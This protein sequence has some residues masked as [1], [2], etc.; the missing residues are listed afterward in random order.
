MM[1][2]MWVRD[3]GIARDELAEGRDDGEGIEVVGLPGG[4]GDGGRGTTRVPW[5]P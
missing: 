3:L 5:V 4:T 1:M 2:M